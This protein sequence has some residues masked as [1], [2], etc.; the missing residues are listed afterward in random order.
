MG[1]Q[2]TKLSEAH[3]SLQQWGNDKMQAKAD[4]ALQKATLLRQADELKAK[5]SELESGFD[6]RWKEEKQ[7]RKQ[8]RDEL[9]KAEYAKDRTP[10]DVMR[11][12]ESRNTVLFYG[13]RQEYLAYGYAPSPEVVTAAPVDNVKWQYHDFKGTH[14]YAVSE[15]ND[16]LRV[17]GVIG[18]P[19]EGLAFVCLNGDNYDF[20][21]GDKELYERTSKSELDRRA[22]TLEEI[23]E[24]TY[25]GKMVTEDNP[26]R[27]S[28]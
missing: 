12:L 6:G 19:D 5:V 7:R 9:I 27:P 21:Y 2:V 14:R 16:K 17:H 10:Q 23:L 15:D 26:Y 3:Y 18:T 22:S 8:V 24:G 4:L 20:L 25:S 13:L 1:R 28:L 11:E